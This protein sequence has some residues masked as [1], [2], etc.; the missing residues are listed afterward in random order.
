MYAA[1]SV[2]IDEAV[3]IKLD[4]AGKDFE[5]DK[6]TTK[7]SMRAKK[8]T[9]AMEKVIDYTHYVR[10]PRPLISGLMSLRARRIILF[11]SLLFSGYRR[12]RRSPPSLYVFGYNG[13]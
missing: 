7:L 1:K 13:I 5:C 6:A 2:C 12:S 9:A 11:I 4:S 3:G 8:L 10:F